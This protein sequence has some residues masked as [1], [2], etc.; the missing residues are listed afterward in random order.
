MLAEHFI[1]L[2]ELNTVH[3]SKIDRG[4]PCVQIIYPLDMNSYQANRDA[5]GHPENGLTHKDSKK[6]L[7]TI[8]LNLDADY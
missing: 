6:Y 4:Y 3:G 7:F 8:S 5:E 2:D 1:M